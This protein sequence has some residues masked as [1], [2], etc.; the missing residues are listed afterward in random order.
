MKVKMSLRFRM[1]IITTIIL[2][3][4]GIIFT[5]FSVFNLNYSLVIP[6]R[7]SIGQEVQDSSGTIVSA[8]L[9]E[10]DTDIQISVSSII[11]EFNKKMKIYIYLSLAFMFFTILVGIM[12]MYKVSGTIIAPVQRLKEEITSIDKNE[13]SFRITDFDAGDE[14]NQLADS[15]N[16]MLDRLESSFSRETRFISDAAHEIKTPL[17]VIRTNIDV[18]SIDDNPTQEEIK[19]SMEV[20]KRQTDRLSALMDTLLEMARE[21][22]CQMDGRVY[23]DDLV[24][25]IILELKSELLHRNIST[26]TEMNHV[27]VQANPVMLK[28]ALL[29][30]IENAVKYNEESGKIKVH[31]YTE[32]SNCYIQVSDT[33]PGISEEHVQHIFDPFYRVDKSR[34]RKIGGSGLGLAISKEIIT[35]H[36]GQIQYERNL[37][38]GSIF[39]VSIKAI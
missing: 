35:K 15:F 20:I 38:K 3:V 32:K 1:T 17:A 16:I 23:V 36:N 29:N 11:Q 37:P 27:M 28:H 24:K 10:N 4:V 8:E 25:E 21:N 18:L 30:I 31:I 5:I 13:L 22:D 34:S 19:K 7:N 39:T 26:E 12:I 33:G 9:G 2:V 6:I 14:L